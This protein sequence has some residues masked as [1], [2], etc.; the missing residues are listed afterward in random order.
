[1]SNV[2]DIENEFFLKIEDADMEA[3][4]PTSMCDSCPRR[5]DVTSVALMDIEQ[6]LVLDQSEHSRKRRQRED[7]SR[8]LWLLRF[9]K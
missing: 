8:N 2:S 3:C 7:T 9:L 4:V 5:R 6:T 1:M